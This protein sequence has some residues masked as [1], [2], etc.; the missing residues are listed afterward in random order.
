MRRND[1]KDSGMRNFLVGGD[2]LFPV[3]ATDTQ[4]VHFVKIHQTVQS[5]LCILLYINYT[6]IRN[7]V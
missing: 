7:N 2:V 4:D 6:S 1:W 5:S 3:V